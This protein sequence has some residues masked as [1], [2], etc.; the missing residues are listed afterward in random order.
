LTKTY[1]EFGYI[2][3]SITGRPIY[4]PGEGPTIAKLLNYSIQ[5]LEAS[6]NIIVLE[7]L[8]KYLKDKYSK[9][10]LYTYDAFLLD[11]SK[12]DGKAT[13]EDI[14]NILSMEDKYAVKFKYGKTLNF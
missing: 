9:L 3:D 2:K 4:I 12:K 8:L 5:S 6:R 14:Q 10:I 11:F 1:E 13:L 7:R